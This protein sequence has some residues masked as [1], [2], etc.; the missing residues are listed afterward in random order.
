MAEHDVSQSPQRD[1][2]L[3]TSTQAPEQSLN[4]GAHSTPHSPSWQTGT[5][6]A[7]LGHSCPHRPQFIKSVVASTQLVP[8]G[9]KPPSHANEH[10]E[11]RHTGPA[12]GGELQ[13]VPHERQFLSSSASTTQ[14]PPHTVSPSRQVTSTVPVPPAPSVPPCGLVSVPMRTQTSS[15]LQK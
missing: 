14:A 4:P 9:K 5:P 1:G 7:A 2:S 11:S 10:C 13:V 3:E 6:P 8:H 12:C 15:V